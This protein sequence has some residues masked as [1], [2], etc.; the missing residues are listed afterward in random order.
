MKNVARTLVLLV[1]LTALPGCE[2]W[3]NWLDLWK[4]RMPDGRPFGQDDLAAND[5]GSAAAGGSV[6]AVVPRVI[7]HR[8]IAPVGTFST[9]EK[10]W[11]ELSEDAIDSK[12]AVLMAQNGLRAGIAPTARWPNIAKLIDGPGVNADQMLCQT[13]GRSSLSI[14]TRQNVTEQIVVSIDRDLQQQG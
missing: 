14:M 6:V 10:V 13:D 4:W 12:T 2:C 3:N 1:L 9:N 11:T 5:G 7:V 8:I